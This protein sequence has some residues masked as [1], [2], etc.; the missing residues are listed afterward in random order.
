MHLA[1]CWPVPSAGPPPPPAHPSA[2]MSPAWVRPAQHSMATTITLPQPDQQQSHISP[3]LSRC[4]KAST[5]NQ[6]AQSLAHRNG[7]RGTRRS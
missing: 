7:A 5:Q 1:S 2:D 3:E 4:A 6:V